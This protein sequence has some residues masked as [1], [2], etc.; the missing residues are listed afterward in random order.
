MKKI[1]TIK[2]PLKTG[3]HPVKINEVGKI[4]TFLEVRESIDRKYL[5]IATEESD[6]I[7]RGQIITDSEKIIIIKEG[8]ELSASNLVYIGSVKLQEF[9]V[10]EPVYGYVYY[11]EFG[12]IK[13]KR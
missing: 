7:N 2:V 8:Q 3:I 4:H 10:N 1:K 6:E 13:L 5:I 12:Q 11:K 9:S